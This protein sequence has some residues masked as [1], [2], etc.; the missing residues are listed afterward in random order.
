MTRGTFAYSLKTVFCVTLYI[1]IEQLWRWVHWQH[2][3]IA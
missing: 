1:V 2:N 3:S